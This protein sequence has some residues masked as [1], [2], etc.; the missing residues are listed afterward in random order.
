VDTLWAQLDAGF[1]CMMPFC[2]RALDVWQRKATLAGG[3][4]S[5]GGGKLQALNQSVT[6]QVRCQPSI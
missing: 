1:K 6:M 3:S 4:L 2:G 5:G